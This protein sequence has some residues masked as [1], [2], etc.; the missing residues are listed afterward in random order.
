MQSVGNRFDKNVAESNSPKS[1]VRQ[2]VFH[3]TSQLYCRWRGLALQDDTSLSN[4]IKTKMCSAFGLNFSFCTMSVCYIIALG[5]TRDQQKLPNL[6]VR[7]RRKMCSEG[8]PPRE[9]TRIHHWQWS[10]NWFEAKHSK[11]VKL[12]QSFLSFRLFL[13]WP[14]G[15]APNS[16][17]VVVSVFR[18]PIYFMQSKNPSIKVP[19]SWTFH[20]PEKRAQSNRRSWIC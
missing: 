8:D 9:Q 6:M 3:L 19:N 15:I 17:I 18:F 14:A 4:A 20:F 16:N 7:S 13:R 2:L 12:L 5:N 1:S 11:P 10:L